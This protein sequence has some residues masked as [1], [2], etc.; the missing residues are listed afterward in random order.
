MRGILYLASVN[1]CLGYRILINNDRANVLLV[2]PL[3][4]L[5]GSSL[6]LSF[7]R[8]F[9]AGLF[10]YHVSAFFLRYEKTCDHHSRFISN[11][12]IENFTRPVWR[13]AAKIE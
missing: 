9:I 12:L 2:F 7:V 8:R 11:E 3:S 4:F 1:E 6:L 13:Y 10:K 5:F